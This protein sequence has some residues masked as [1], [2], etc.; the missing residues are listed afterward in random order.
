M[1]RRVRANDSYPAFASKLECSV[2][3]THNWSFYY[4]ASTHR[5]S[6]RAEF[7]IGSPAAGRMEAGI[8]LHAVAMVRGRR[9]GAADF[10]EDVVSQ[11]HYPIA[12]DE[13]QMIRSARRLCP[14]ATNR[15]SADALALRPTCPVPSEP[16]NG[17]SGVT[18]TEPSRRTRKAASP[19]VGHG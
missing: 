16:V 5:R 6:F 8:D 13:P 18:A 4:G 15:E 7:A 1:N 3:A 14:A 10:A 19:N 17:A 12:D 9:S 11:A 2:N